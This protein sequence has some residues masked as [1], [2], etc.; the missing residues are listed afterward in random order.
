MVPLEC[1]GCIATFDRTLEQL[2]L[3]TSTQMPHVV[4]TGLS[5]CLGLDER[6]VRVVAPDVGGGFGYKGMLHQEEVCIAWLAMR[7]GKPVKWIEDRRE[8]L[9]ASA[10]CREHHYDIT[11][12]AAAD[13][14][15]L[16]ID[17]VVHVDS[18]AYSAY[19]YSS[20]LEAAQVN[21]ILPAAYIIEALRCKAVA[22]CTN[23]PPIVPYRGV[24]RT[25]C[26]FAIELMID[27]VAREL[28]MD[29][30][31]LRLKNLPKPDAMPLTTITGKN[32][33]GGDYP[34][35]VAKAREMLKQSS[36]WSWL[37]KGA[38]DGRLVGIGFAFYFEQG[39]HGTS[40]YKSWGIPMIPGIE[41]CLAR[42]T[43]D[44][45]VEVRTGLQSHGQSM[46]TTFAQI[47]SE[48]LS[49]NPKLVNIIHGD[50][51][52]SPY[53]TGTWG[54]RAAVM[55]GGAVARACEVLSERLK[56]IGAH[57]LQTATSDVSISHAHVTSRS[58]GSSV[59]FQQIANTWYYQPHN[60][61]IDVDPSGLEV[62]AGYKAKVDTG[63]FS[64]GAHG[65][66]VAVDPML[67]SVELLDYVVVEDG[68]TLINPM[69]ADGQI[70]GGT[71]QGIGS[72]LYEETPFDENGQPLAST[73]ADYIVPGA[74]EIPPIRIE[75]LHTPS[76]NTRFGQK[77]IGEGGAVPPPAA[78]GNAINDALK[79]LRAEVTATP[80][81]PSR[82]LE[83]I[84]ASEA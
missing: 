26:C 73:F 14:R 83:A 17:A 12:F 30:V 72:A 21:G 79:G 34:Q 46:E 63:T 39:A 37:E 40:V 82:V 76:P 65:A 43:P 41:Q 11:A 13:G 49:I 71:A 54:S 50:T 66:L 23:K 68:G 22:V 59:S 61:P 19:P 48:I 4:R 70:Y 29:P 51:A 1:K 9:S 31:E 67:G 60:L 75:H 36:R 6:Q 33:D 28:N 8:H 52:L 27:A 35:C 24:A 10:N 47:A 15:L 38:P 58:G 78:I 64:Y 55:G 25:G 7:L 16:A 80:F 5:Q 45:G 53:S 20:C 74:N 69:V 32:L 44:G 56:A 81:S 42:M 57:L 2:V 18:G 84:A 3:T 62:V 77:G